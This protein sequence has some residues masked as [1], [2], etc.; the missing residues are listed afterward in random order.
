VNVSGVWIIARLT[1]KEAVRRKIVL[2]ALLLGVAFL[3]VY[4]L[5]LHFIRADLER[6]PGRQSVLLRNQLY[7]FALLSGLYVVNFLFAVMAVLT[8]VDTVA[9]EI[10]SGTIQ[11]LAAKPVRRWEI[12]LGKW[13]GFVV[14]L[15]LYLLL[16]AGGVTALA[17]TITGYRA[18]NVARGLALIWLNGTLL[19][20]ITLLGG[21]QL[22][23]LANGVLVF[24]T[25]GVA[26]VGGWVEQIGSF[27]ES[28]AAVK[29]G[30]ISS[31]LMPSEALWK[32]AAYEM[33]SLVVDAVGFSPFTSAASVP[34][35]AMILYAVGYALLGLALALWRFQRRDL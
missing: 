22:S 12:L 30:I 24:A 31:L 21:T 17:E 6:G 19:L 5:G 29:V 20:N 23:T 11:A 35:P 1:L 10:T 25:F 33:R 26:F 9:G 34:S 15:T 8:S 14:M 28:D 2:G 16:M 18:P 7:N 32:R 27:L 3:V 13:L 4:G